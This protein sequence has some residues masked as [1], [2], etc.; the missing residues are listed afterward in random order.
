MPQATP[1]R[2]TC[3]ARGDPTPA[4]RSIIACMSLL[5]T[6]AVAGCV[7]CA[8]P[9][10]SASD[11]GQSPQDALARCEELYAQYWRYRSTG[12]QSPQGSSY[13]GMLE[14]DAAVENCRRGNTRDGIAALRR[15]VGSGGCV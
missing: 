1:R 9:T 10:A 3:N 2:T 5:G 14:A 8:A 6:L 4:A 11:V 12:G 7:E 15:K 13:Q